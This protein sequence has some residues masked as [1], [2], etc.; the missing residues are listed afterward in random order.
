[1]A[2]RHR[3]VTTLFL[4]SAGCV[5]IPALTDPDG[6]PL[7]GNVMAKGGPRPKPRPQPHPHPDGAHRADSDP[8]PA[9]PEGTA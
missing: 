7:V 9:G 3:I 1:M 4:L 8:G 6:Y 2:R 5:S